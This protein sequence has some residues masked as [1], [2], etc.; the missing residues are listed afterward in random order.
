M[1]LIASNGWCAVCGH[2]LSFSKRY[3]GLLLCSDCSFLTADLKLSDEELTKLYGPDYFH[4]GEYENYIAEKAALQLNFK[5]RLKLI[6]SL[7]SIG[8]QSQIFEIGCAYGFFLELLSGQ[9]ANAAGIDIAED[10]TK[11]AREVLNVDAIHGNFIDFEPDFNPDVICLWDVIEHLKNPREVLEHAHQI[12]APK[13]Y[14]LITTGD[15]QSINARLRGPKW[16]LIHP[17]TH[18]HYFSK[19]SIRSLLQDVGYENIRISYPSV[20]RTIGTIMHAIVDQRLG[21]KSIYKILKNIPGF[22]IPIPLNLF[23]IM[24][25]TAQKKDIN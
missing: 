16:R 5:H 14:V 6:F 7:P 17:P 2:N 19:K 22:N 11:Y 24:L 13:G 10:A 3:P 18:L 25:I 4:D 21:L 8:K 15:V 9:F 1:N 20:W 12:T 23:D